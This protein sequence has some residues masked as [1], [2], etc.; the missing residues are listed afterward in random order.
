MN[1]QPIPLTASRT[2]YQ[3][4][5]ENKGNGFPTFQPVLLLIYQVSNKL[6][7]LTHHHG[8][9]ILQVVKRSIN[10][11]SQRK[12]DFCYRCRPRHLLWSR[13]RLHLREGG[14]LLLWQASRHALQL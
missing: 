5:I 1:E 8:L 2:R 11:Q 4:K 3:I 13:G 12:H 10:H 6:V 14:D 7:F 9:R